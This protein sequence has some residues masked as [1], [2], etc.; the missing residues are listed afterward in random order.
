MTRTNQTPHPSYLNMG[1]YHPACTKATRNKM[2]HVSHSPQ[3]PHIHVMC[4]NATF[5]T[6]DSAPVPPY[7]GVMHKYA[8]VTRTFFNKV[9]VTDIEQRVMRNT[10]LLGLSSS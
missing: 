6:P 7:L 8:S 10:H 2:P 3:N 4:L 5:L 9:A 1:K